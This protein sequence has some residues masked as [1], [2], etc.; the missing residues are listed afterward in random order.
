L[1][2]K[3]FKAKKTVVITSYSHMTPPV[4]TGFNTVKKLSLLFKI[5]IINNSQVD[6]FQLEACSVFGPF[7]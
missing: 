7:V 5:I 2:G 4:L 3:K 6:T 1:W